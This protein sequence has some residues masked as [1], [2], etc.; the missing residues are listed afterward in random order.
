MTV[1]T[2]AALRTAKPLA[3]GPG[4]APGLEEC[5]AM[6]AIVAAR[7]TPFAPVN[8]ALSRWHPV[9]LCA[10]LLAATVQDPESLDALVIECQSPVGAQGDNM[11]RAAVLAAGWPE[12]LP[13]FVVSGGS[14][15]LGALVAG[16]GL[17]ATGM[18]RVCV[19]GCE[20]MSA[21]PMGASAMAR[22][23][24]GKPWGDRVAARYA[25]AGG[26]LPEG[27]RVE[28][29]AAELAITRAQQD[30]WSAQSIANAH[31]T[32]PSP[33]LVPIGNLFTDV[34]CH[35]ADTELDL[36][37]PLFDADGSVTAGNSA[38]IADGA[39]AVVIERA[40]G[41][42]RTVVA[43]RAAGRSPCGALPITP[44]LFALA[45]AQIGWQPHELDF[46]ELH[47]GF[48]ATAIETA[49]SLPAVPIN[50]RG[51][52]LAYGNPHGAAGLRLVSSVWQQL[53]TGQRGAAVYEAGEIAMVVL[54]GG[55]AD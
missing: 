6:V 21:V 50:Q 11:A 12:S 28:R 48:A 39:V 17:V 13:A 23:A 47:E 3:A 9:D 45:C 20:V 27:H 8:G 7:R 55:R 30:A 44:G 51:G 15:G 31:S 53:G 1:V 37:P 18:Q 26:L 43:T 54:L 24:Y 49:R 32:A 19:V 46:I 10:E 22:Q 2:A 41:P 52:A 4:A 25:N 38:V 35:E 33:E 42:H 5:R 29:R 14:G 16:A 40:G 34:F 36:L